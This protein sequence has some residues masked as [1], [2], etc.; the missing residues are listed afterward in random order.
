MYKSN[1]K[2]VK[3]NQWWEY[4]EYPSHFGVDCNPLDG[5]VVVGCNS[6]HNILTYFKFQYMWFSVVFLPIFLIPIN[7]K[8]LVRVVDEPDKTFGKVEVGFNFL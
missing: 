6:I 1:P 8:Q 7:L 5:A 3:T 4:V 2:Q